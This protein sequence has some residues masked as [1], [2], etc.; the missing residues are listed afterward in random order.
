MNSKRINSLIQGLKC[1]KVISQF[2]HDVMLEFVP[3]WVKENLVFNSQ[4]GT[5][6]NTAV[7]YDEFFYP[8]AYVR[9]EDRNFMLQLSL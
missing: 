7:I 5:Y 8:E 1:K 6:D 9:E 3:A 4:F 2:E